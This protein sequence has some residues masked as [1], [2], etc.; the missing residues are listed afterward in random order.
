MLFIFM[1]SAAGLLT[2]GNVFVVL[3]AGVLYGLGWL[4]I[5][6]AEAERQKRVD[7]KHQG[8]FDRYDKHI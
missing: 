5:Q 7:A 2:G 6:G 3:G 4:F 8:R 1:I